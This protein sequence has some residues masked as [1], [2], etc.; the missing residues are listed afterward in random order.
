M[1]LDPNSNSELKNL[2]WE[3]LIRSRPRFS[4]RFTADEVIYHVQSGT[5][6]RRDP[7]RT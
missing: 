4:P 7:I 3:L 2:N 1:P 6:A 5:N